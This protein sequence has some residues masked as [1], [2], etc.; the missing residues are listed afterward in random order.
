MCIF[1]FIKSPVDLPKYIAIYVLSNFIGSLSLW[2]YLP[3]YILKINYKKFDFKKHIKPAIILFIPQIATQ[4]Y[5]VLDKTMIGLL[6]ENKAEVGYYEQAQKIVKLLM[7][8]ATSLG[9][10]MMPRIANTYMKGETKKMKEYMNNSF[11]F[12]LLLAFPLMF[13]I[14]SISNKFVPLFYGKGY[15]KVI[16]LINI[17]SPIIVII[18]LSNVI[19]TQYLLPTNQQ[20]KF[21]I[22]VILGAI[23]NF[24]LNLLLIPHWKSIGASI[25][26]VF[27]ELIVTFTQFILVKNEF[28]FMYI[29]KISYK[30]IISSII[31]FLCS[32][33]IGN[34]I[35]NYIF[36]IS[37]QIIIS[38]CIYFI[39]LLILKDKMLLYIINK[40]LRK[41]EK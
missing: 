10:V 21:T 11:S 35:K 25:A 20:K 12:I 41:K 32:I 26:T 15:D 6:V 24:I 33:F 14:I 39:I 3:K 8:L 40:I 38:I 1:I 9:T 29:V 22:T 23:V 34:Y 36:S 18:G 28:S 7:T 30:Y 16:Y 2:F 27:A 31:M 19:G 13:G 37:I 4:I 17:I 5:T